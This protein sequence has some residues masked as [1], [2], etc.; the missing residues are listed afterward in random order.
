MNWRVSAFSVIFFMLF[1]YLGFWQLQRGE[2][3]EQLLVVME[4]KSKANPL[5]VRDLETPL[6]KIRGMP[7]YA[8]GRFA[9]DQVVLLDNRV[10]KGQV[11]FELLQTFNVSGSGKRILVN[12]GFVPMG[13]RRT[14]PLPIPSTFDAASVKGIIY[15]PA[16]DNYVIEAGVETI[17][18]N[19]I[20]QAVDFDQISQ[21]LGEDFHPFVL[22]LDREEAAALPRHWPVTVML[23][24]VHYGYT[25][26]WFLMAF[27]IFMMYLWFSFPKTTGTTKQ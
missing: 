1:T 18:N 2:E 15:V 4:E 7:F 13:K 16:E 26:Q 23:P 27:A 19:L 24:G 22:R 17:G 9:Q 25:V 8:S 5:A 21:Q 6:D 14:D 3:K 10:L 12:R 11:G 20:V